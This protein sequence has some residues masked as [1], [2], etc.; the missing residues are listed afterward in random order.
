MTKSTNL[1]HYGTPLYLL[2][3][4][5]ISL[6]YFRVELNNYVVNYY[7]YYP[8]QD[9]VMSYQHE[10]SY[11]GEKIDKFA[12]NNTV[13][14]GVPNYSIT[15]INN[16]VVEYL[17][18]LVSF[19]FNNHISILFLL[20]TCFYFMMLGF[21]FTKF[22]SFLASVA[23]AFV[24][25]N[26]LLLASGEYD[27]L[28]FLTYLPLVITGLHKIS[29]DQ[30][31]VGGLFFSIGVLF[32]GLY[33][34]YQF[35]YYGVIFGLV[36]ILCQQSI[37]LDKDQLLWVL[38][39]AV[40]ASLPNL[41]KYWYYFDYA[42][43][44]YVTTDLLSG[45]ARGWTDLKENSLG[46]ADLLASL[47]NPGINGTAVLFAE[48]ADG[49]AG[50]LG[51]MQWSNVYDLNGSTAVYGIMGIM[52]IVY[53]LFHKANLAHEK[54]A[55]V[56]FFV[57]IFTALGYNFLPNR[58]LYMYM[59]G[60]GSINE[61]YYIMCFLPMVIFPIVFRYFRIMATSFDR[62]KVLYM[63]YGYLL[64]AVIIISFLVPILMGFQSSYPK[65]DG[66]IMDMIISERKHLLGAFTGLLILSSVV[67]A[68]TNRYVKNEKLVMAVL[69]LSCCGIYLPTIYHSYNSNK[70]VNTS[71]YTTIFRP[72]EKHFD[73]MDKYGYFRVY[74]GHAGIW[75][76]ESS[77]WLY[78]I[79]GDYTRPSNKYA[80]FMAVYGP[81]KSDIGNQLLNVK[82]KLHSDKKTGDP[83]V[84]DN[85]TFGEA[86]FC[87]SV[88]IVKDDEEEL[89]SLARTTHN[90]AIVSVDEDL[91]P[92]YKSKQVPSVELT[93]I[94]N[95]NMI[96]YVETDTQRLLVMP[97]I[98]NKHWKAH[99]NDS[100]INI[101]EVDYML[102]GVIVPSGKYKL[103]LTFDPVNRTVDL[104]SKA[105]TVLFLIC[106]LL[107]V[108]GIINHRKHIY[109]YE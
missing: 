44:A 98:Y 56:S 45:G 42:W 10:T 58:L 17:N 67:V 30:K 107:M 11:I 83:V 53:L 75:D 96:Y 38:L 27:K 18:S 95:R 59:P 5:L 61:P 23:Y 49:L 33:F 31:L 57:I 97:E 15:G 64:I 8:I 82:Y 101:Y 92:V 25:T 28:Q 88:I 103:K 62:S 12:W 79:G 90:I 26:F 14:S 60:Y 84:D 80:N 32:C 13:Y 22:T 24:P 9:K 85:I 7:N 6:L 68:A 51:I 91:P 99:L 93:D 66:N 72:N 50:R 102:R 19:G 94:G 39:C 108:M 54:W 77:A 37:K 104:I 78:S 71:E 21:G 87:D 35:Y 86:W 16:P 46:Y 34:D 40:I 106:V 43:D 36:Y 89:I 4:L 76:S 29:V 81:E 20:M 2:L 3:F 65:F 52:F 48:G 41:V 1:K 74:D 70:F 105:S 109:D 63:N 100:Q 73:V 55:K 47:F 69:V